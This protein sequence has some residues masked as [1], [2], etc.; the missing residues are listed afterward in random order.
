[1]Q[2]NWSFQQS[3]K[4]PVSTFRLL[5]VWAQFSSLKTVLTLTPDHGRTIGRWGP[6]WEYCPCTPPSH[7]HR[8]LREQGPGTCWDPAPNDICWSLHTGHCMKGSNKADLCSLS[9]YCR[10]SCLWWLTRQQTKYTGSQAFLIKDL[11]FQ[12]MSCRTGVIVDAP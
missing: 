7:L 5:D 10:T 1:M 2:D 3:P 11:F 4:W 8:A 9:L 6:L 12:G